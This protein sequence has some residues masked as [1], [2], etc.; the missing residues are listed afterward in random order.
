MSLKNTEQA[1]GKL[2]IV[3]HWLM[4]LL[5]IGLVVLG[6]ILDDIDKA[7]RLTYINLHKATGFLVLILALF[8]WF[9]TL[10]S[11]QVKPLPNWSKKDIAISHS[12]KWALMVLMIVMP[13]SGWIM[14]NYAGYG[15]NFYGLFEIPAFLEKNKEMG[16][17]FHEIH[18]IG[19]FIIATLIILHVLAAIKHHVIVK[20]DTL[21][22]MLGRSSSEQ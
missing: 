4:A 9:L 14:S 13:V 1:Y 10:T 22:R 12:V 15:I 21:K 7:Q 16:G 6:F 20:D 5:I 17:I 8:R 19:G 11:P 2:T 18:E 3:L